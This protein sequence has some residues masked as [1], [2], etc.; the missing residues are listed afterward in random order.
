MRASTLAGS[1]STLLFVVS[2]LPMVWR[3]ARTR[4]LTS[5]SLGHLTIT[6]VGNLVYTV[7]VV[8]LPLGPV[9]ALHALNTAVAA[10]ML[11]WKVRHVVCSETTWVCTDGLRA[12]LLTSHDFGVSA[13]DPSGRGA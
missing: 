13:S 10:T 7:Y 2:L 6:N 12:T 9:W 5:Y 11:M 3:A 4:D 8:S 1:A